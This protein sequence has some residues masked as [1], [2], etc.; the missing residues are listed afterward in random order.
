M[1]DAL[2][3]RLP[4]EAGQVCMASHECLLSPVVGNSRGRPADVRAMRL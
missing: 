1:D 3:A 2:I 4:P